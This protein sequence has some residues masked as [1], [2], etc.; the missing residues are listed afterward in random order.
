MCVCGHFA[1][2]WHQKGH[3]NLLASAHLFMYYRVVQAKTGTY[4]HG[5]FHFLCTTLHKTNVY[6][7][8]VMVVLFYN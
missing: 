1:T 3:C 4:I 5:N 6:V 7:K 8:Q 2:G